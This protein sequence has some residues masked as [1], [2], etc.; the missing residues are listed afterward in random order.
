MPKRDTEKKVYVVCQP[1][2]TQKKKYWSYVDKRK[3]IRQHEQ[4]NDQT[5]FIHKFNSA[6]DKYFLKLFL[7]HLTRLD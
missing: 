5:K 7:G 6:T 2:F 3:N 4:F 1:A